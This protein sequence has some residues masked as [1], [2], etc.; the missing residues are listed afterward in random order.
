MRPCLD[1]LEALLWI[2]RLGSFRAAGRKLHLSQPAISGRIRELER[3][4]GFGVLDRSPFR[5]GV[6][7]RG[8][9]VVRYAEQ[10]IALAEGFRRRLA[11]PAL[12]PASIRMGAADSFAHTFLSPLLT[13][14]AERH[15]GVD[16]ELAIEFSANLNRKLHADELDIAFLTA[17]SAG[18][19]VTI[20]PLLDLELAWL[21]SPRFALPDGRLTPA[22]LAGVP[23]ITNPRPSHLYGTIQGWFAAAGLVPQRLHTCT[24]LTIMANLT[25]DAFGISVLP[26]LF[27]EH[28]I[29]RGRLHRL[30]CNPSLPMHHIAVAWR[31]EPGR[32]D[33]YPIAEIAR[34]VVSGSTASMGRPV[35]IR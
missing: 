35:G 23:I 7:E 14:I 27:L 8:Q 34:D 26:P 10:M 17:P 12:L 29:A 1:Q 16:V 15:P 6:T 20:E 22:G 4:L 13:R 2:A 31:S 5:P 32:L 18:Q 21:A 19:D 30:S 33:L 11:G 25:A 3:D 24:S 9:E 28:D